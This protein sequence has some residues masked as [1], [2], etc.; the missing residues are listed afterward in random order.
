[1]LTLIEKAQSVADE[2]TQKAM[3]KKFAKNSF[4]LEDYLTQMDQVAQMGGIEEVMGSLPIPAGKLG[5]MKVDP[6]QMAR[7]KAV[8]L[9]MTPKERQNPNIINASR[10]RRIAAGSGTTVTDVNRL[11][12]G[13]EQSKK[14]MKQMASNKRFGSKGKF[15]FM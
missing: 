4:T 15:P 14:L 12:K 10:R 13:F 3:A 1:M 8:I 11:L 6:K 9:S 7:T 2:Q 5:N